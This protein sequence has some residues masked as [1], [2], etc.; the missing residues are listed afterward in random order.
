MVGAVPIQPLE[1]VAAEEV[2]LRL[3]ALRRVQRVGAHR[4]V[5][6]L[7]KVSKAQMCE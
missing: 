5:V 2:A 4:V 6:G 1:A 3:D 7:P